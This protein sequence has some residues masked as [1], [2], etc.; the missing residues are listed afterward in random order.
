MGEP[1]RRQVVTC[2][3]RRKTRQG[4]DEVLLLRRSANVGTYRGMWAGISGYLEE[5]T[6]FAQAL[7]E[8]AEE[9]GLSTADVR[10]VTAGDSLLIDD[11]ERGLRWLVYPFLFDLITDKPVSLDWEN[12]EAHWIA[13]ADLPKYDTV[14]GL[15]DALTR[16]YGGTA[17]ETQ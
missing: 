7:R 3:L 16:V 6:P 1:Q 15:A 14:P 11:D 10:L 13:P 9:T 2:F 17:G 4:N 12:V 8:I 5:A